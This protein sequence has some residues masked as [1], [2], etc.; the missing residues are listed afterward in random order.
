M[1]NTTELEDIDLD[2]IDQFLDRQLIIKQRQNLMKLLKL[3]RRRK[4]RIILQIL[5][6]L[7][8]INFELL[9]V[10]ARNLK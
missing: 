9:L 4:I 6:G 1:E 5:F 3:L 7:Q 8:R 10:R 2:E